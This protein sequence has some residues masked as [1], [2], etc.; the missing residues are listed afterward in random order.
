MLADELADV[1]LLEEPDTHMHP[2]YVRELVYFLIELAREDDVRLFVTTHDNDFFVE[3]LT[4]E[5]RAFLDAEFR[6]VQ[7]QDDGADVMDDEE[8]ERTLTE[9]KRDLRGL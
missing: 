9:L 7:M 6:L 3:N 2:G 5:E 4:D 1:V 8:A